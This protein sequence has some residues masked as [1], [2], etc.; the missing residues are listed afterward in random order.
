MLGRLLNYSSAKG[1]YQ[2]AEDT[3]KEYGYDFCEPQS[4]DS[5]ILY[6]YAKTHFT[7]RAIKER[8]D[9]ESGRFS[10]FQFP[11]TEWN[12]G[13][14]DLEKQEEQE[15]FD[16]WVYQTALDLWEE[17]SDKALP[18]SLSELEGLSKAVLKNKGYYTFALAQYRKIMQIN[19]FSDVEE[20]I[21]Q[22]KNLL[23]DMQTWI[24]EL[25]SKIQTEK[26]GLLES[27]VF[28]ISRSFLAAP[29]TSSRS[30]RSPVRSAAKSSG[31]GNAGEDSD[32]GSDPEPPRPLIYT[33][34][35]IL[36]RGGE[37]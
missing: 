27:P 36:L 23:D 22:A 1:N 13:L 35:L 33:H 26:N 7:K 20:F 10:P 9:P 19:R 15:R 5:K 25:K 32:G 4:D 17:Y 8:F 34:R 29:R 24:N 21:Y 12:S 14:D 31:D 3:L 16:E 11:W 30:R 18:R 28:L 2:V 37:I 6:A